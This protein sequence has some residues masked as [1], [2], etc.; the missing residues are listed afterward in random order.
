MPGL[1]VRDRDEAAPESWLAR[2]RAG[3]VKHNSV[4]PLKLQ[5]L[6]PPFEPFKIEVSAVRPAGRAD[7]GVAWL[8]EGIREALA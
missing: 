8:L 1:S 7:A 6:K 5:I 2:L 3:Q 4:N